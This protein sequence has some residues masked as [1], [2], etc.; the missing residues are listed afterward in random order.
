[1]GTQVTEDETVIEVRVNCPNEA[2]ASAIADRI[3]GE[4]GRSLL[5]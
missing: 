3:E 5:F 2:R 4:N 1:M